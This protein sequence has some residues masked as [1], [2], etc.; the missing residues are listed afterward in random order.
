MDLVDLRFAERRSRGKPRVYVRKVEKRLRSR[1]G[2][3]VSKSIAAR[4]L[5]VSTNTLEKWIKRGQVPVLAGPGE[6]QIV[7][8]GP[9][10]DLAAEIEDLR[11]LGRTEGLLA[12][13]ILRLSQ[14]DP[15]YL[16]DFAELYG[17]GLQAAA[18]G[19]LVPAVIP[20]TFGPGD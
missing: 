10:V 2:S 9:L 4:T 1:L 8:L 19:D 15:T 13:A 6:R 18:D 7:A 20:D 3:G 12:K 5:G 14:K 17:D 16:S 11:D